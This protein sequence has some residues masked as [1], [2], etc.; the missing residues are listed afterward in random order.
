MELLC[1]VLENPEIGWQMR[2][3][4]LSSLPISRDVIFGRMLIDAG[5]APQ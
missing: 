2:V 5:T 4:K 1:G 3:F